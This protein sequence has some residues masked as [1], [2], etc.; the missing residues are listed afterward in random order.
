MDHD[1]YACHG[2]GSRL[3][4]GPASRWVAELAATTLQC[5]WRCYKYS[6]VYVDYISLLSEE[7]LP[8]DSSDPHI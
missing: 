1:L 5:N 2:L 7:D 8:P 3:R 6:R 4:L